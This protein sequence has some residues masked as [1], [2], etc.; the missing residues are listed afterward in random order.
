MWG[1]ILG[2]PYGEST[3]DSVLALRVRLRSLHR[4]PP[5]PRPHGG[6]SCRLRLLRGSPRWGRVCQFDWGSEESRTYVGLKAG[7]EIPHSRTPT[8]ATT[9][10]ADGESIPELPNGRYTPSRP[11]AS[12]RALPR[13]RPFLPPVTN[14]ESGCASV[15]PP[16]VVLRAESRRISLR[17]IPPSL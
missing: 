11:R 10:A 14:Q 5:A 4:P 6:R 1:N 3:R 7:G 8:V 12:E 9:S 16:N 13:T 15:P 2:S 17:M